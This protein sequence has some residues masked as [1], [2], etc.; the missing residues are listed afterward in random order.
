MN[1]VKLT[2]SPIK[3]VR[4]GA[5]TFPKPCHCT[6]QMHP[7]FPQRHDFPKSLHDIQMHMNR[8]KNIQIVY[9]FIQDRTTTPAVRVPAQ[10][11]KKS[12]R[13]KRKKYGF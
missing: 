13:A 1:C 4:P 3:K 11:K 9:I 7:F 6:K 5:K 12:K 8:D 2:E 10:S